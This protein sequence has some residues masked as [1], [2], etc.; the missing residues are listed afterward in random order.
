MEQFELTAPIPLIGPLPRLEEVSSNEG[1]SDILST[2][3]SLDPALPVKSL[4]TRMKH[5]LQQQTEATQTEKSTKE[6]A[7][8]AEKTRQAQEGGR[9]GRLESVLRK[10]RDQAVNYI[11]AVTKKKMAKHVGV[12][13][14]RLPRKIESTRHRYMECPDAGSY[15]APRT[16]FLSVQNSKSDKN[17]TDVSI[18]SS[19]RKRFQRIP[20]PSF[21]ASRK[22]VRPS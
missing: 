14:Q 21:R 6:K 20:L 16:R 2:K 5:L 19:Y 3:I 9:P 11:H 15:E 13:K 22:T 17:K 4:W 10:K 7:K 18:S 1:D 12:E 8:I